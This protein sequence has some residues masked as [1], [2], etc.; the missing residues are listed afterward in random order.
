[1]TL[2]NYCIQIV[3]KID[4]QWRNTYSGPASLPKAHR[5]QYQVHMWGISMVLIFGWGLMVLSSGI[6]PK[7]LVGSLPHLPRGGRLQEALS[8]QQKVWP[9]LMWVVPVSMLV[10][11]TMKLVKLDEFSDFRLF[12]P[13]LLWQ[14]LFIWP[15]NINKLFDPHLFFQSTIIGKKVIYN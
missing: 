12:R 6:L 9:P 8:L 7:A 5:V 3:A 4:M 11:V 15:L 14:F 1:M 10:M 13:P 2:P